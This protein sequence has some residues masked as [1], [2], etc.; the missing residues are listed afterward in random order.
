[1]LGTGM[2]EE[3]KK[4]MK[5]LLKYA[6]WYINK[7]YSL[8]TIIKHLKEVICVPA[9]SHVSGGESSYRVT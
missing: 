1:M 5:N 3:K 8:K 2:P 6:F 4:N 9:R 7:A